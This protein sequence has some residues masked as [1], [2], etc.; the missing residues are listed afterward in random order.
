MSS[1]MM[2]RDLLGFLIYFCY[3]LNLMGAMWLLIGSSS[4]RKSILLYCRFS[5]YC[6]VLMV[7]ERGFIS[8]QT[9][10]FISTFGSMIQLQF[11]GS[12]F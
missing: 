8:F 4:L 10:C 12:S 9:I 5:Y 3:F 11:E 6:S 7:A 1:S 2:A